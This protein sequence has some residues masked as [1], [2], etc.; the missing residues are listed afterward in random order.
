MKITNNNIV[1]IGSTNVD[2]IIK[3]DRIP[4]SGETLI[5]GKFFKAAGGKGANQAVAAARA[6][7]KVTFLSRVGNDVFGQDAIQGYRNDKIDVSHIKVDQTE[8]TGIAL[9]LVDSKGENCI[10]VA[11]GANMKLDQSDIKDATFELDKADVVLM[12]LETPIETIEYI[13]KLLKNRQVKI[14]LNPAPALKISDDL[15]THLTIITPNETEVELLTGVPVNDKKDALKASRILLDK[16]VKN[17]IITMGKKGA[18]LHTKLNYK[19]IPAFEVS[20]L[21]TTA[22]G[23]TF[24]GALAVAVA[25]GKA[26]EDAVEYANAAAAISVTKMGAQPSIPLKKEIEDFLSHIG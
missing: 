23:D 12:Q 5:G 9:I 26:L 22:A 13:I 19:F 21:D 3:G 2:M 15:L 10:S 20:A 25:E 7:G 8:S 24:N 11:S 17:V 1:V 4:K 18:F 14:I 6:G 16:G